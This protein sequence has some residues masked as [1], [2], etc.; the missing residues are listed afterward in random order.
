MSEEN[1]NIQEQPSTKGS[2]KKRKTGATT[3]LKA[4]SAVALAT[5]LIAGSLYATNVLYPKYQ[6]NKRVDQLITSNISNEEICTISGSIMIDKAYDIP[7]ANGE[8]LANKLKDH[9]IKYCE[10]LDQYYTADGSDIAI[11][12]FDVETTEVIDAT[13]TE[14]DGTIIYLAPEGY[15]LQKDKCYRT[16]TSQM[17]KIVPKSNDG[18]YSNVTIPNVASYTL[19]DVQEI[20]TETFDS[21]CDYT[22]ICDVPDEAVLNKDGLC[23]ATLVLKKH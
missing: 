16:T 6:E 2:T 4:I 18:D 9:N 8:T 15:T 10:L 14:I 20:K 3:A 13:K 23:E 11:L 22:L 7:F 19:V 12:T 21:I 1:K 17:T 5:G